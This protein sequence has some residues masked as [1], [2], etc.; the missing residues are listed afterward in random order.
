MRFKFFIF[1]GLM[2]ALTIG[3]FKI[4]NA[5]FASSAVSSNNI[6]STAEVFPT[7]T[8]SETLT[9]TPTG[10]VDETPTPTPD[11]SLHLIIN[12]VFLTGSAAVE[13]VELYNPT[14]N[15]VNL[16]GWK[17][18][19]ATSQ[20]DDL[21]NVSIPSGGYAVIVSSGT[22]VNTSTLSAVI[23]TVSANGVGS[24]LNDTGGDIVELLNGTVVIDSM[25]Y[26]VSGWPATPTAGNTISRIPNGI[27]TDSGSDW[28]TNTVST[29]GVSN[30]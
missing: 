29:I 26:G 17:I 6:F 22:T 1:L 10:E 16:L 2:V 15:P 23:I 24:G 27:D 28:Q 8:P 20:M 30:N 3:T 11:E 14:S 12:E 4:S 5:F 13:W 7:S 9:P 18:K 19:D 21:P 25:S